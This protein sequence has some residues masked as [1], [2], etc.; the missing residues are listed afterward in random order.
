MHRAGVQHGDVS[1]TDGRSLLPRRDLLHFTFSGFI[2]V[3]V[4][5]SDDFPFFRNFHKTCP[6]LHFSSSNLALPQA[7]PGKDR[8]VGFTCLRPQV[9]ATQCR[10]CLVKLRIRAPW[11]AICWE[12]FL[13]INAVTPLAQGRAGR[14]CALPVGRVARWELWRWLC[15][16]SLRTKPADKFLLNALKNINAWFQGGCAPFMF[17]NSKCRLI[18]SPKFARLP[19][20]L[21]RFGECVTSLCFKNSQWLRKARKKGE[22]PDL[23]PRLRWQEEEEDGDCSVVQHIPTQPRTWGSWLQKEETSRGF[24]TKPVACLLVTYSLISANAWHSPPAAALVV[25][26][27]ETQGNKNWQISVV[28]HHHDM[29]SKLVSIVKILI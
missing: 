9:C 20:P 1:S 23:Y 4:L 22:T 26:T 2:C 6:I 15:A 28:P 18:I 16:R 8:L 25:N 7:C 11:P 24:Q 10:R 21:W 27:Q 17:W 13:L 3:W 14:C 19:F 12:Y 29:K 5:A